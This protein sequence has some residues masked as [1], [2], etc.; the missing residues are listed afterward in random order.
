L[1]DRAS[2]VCEGVGVALREGAGC[3]SSRN[4]DRAPDAAADHEGGA[5]LVGNAGWLEEIAVARA[6]LGVSTRGVVEHAH[7]DPASGEGG[8]GVG[9]GDEVLAADQELAGLAGRLG[10]VDPVL[11]ELV[12]RVAGQ[13][14]RVWIQGVPAG[15]V[16]VDDATQPLRQLG[17]VLVAREPAAAEEHDLLMQALRGP[18]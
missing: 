8:E 17:E 15:G 7:G 3:L 6:A 16:V 11:D 13:Q 9:I 10:R 18:P 12:R 5:K 2:H 1:G 4:V 14:P